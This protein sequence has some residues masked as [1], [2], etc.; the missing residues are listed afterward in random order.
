MLECAFSIIELF[1]VWS[2]DE[3]HLIPARH[4]YNFPF[5]LRHRFYRLLFF[6]ITEIRFL[7]PAVLR[8]VD[9]LSLCHL[10]TIEALLLERGLLAGELIGVPYCCTSFFTFYLF[11]P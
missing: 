4:T 3:V 5:H 9:L 1:L 8:E 2:K 10:C 6:I 7:E 11:S